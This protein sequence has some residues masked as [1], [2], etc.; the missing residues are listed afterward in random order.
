MAHNIYFTTTR[1]RNMG[2][3]ILIPYASPSGGALRWVPVYC[4]DIRTYGIDNVLKAVRKMGANGLLL[5]DDDQ[6][7]TSVIPDLYH[8]FETAA[9]EITA[10]P[11]PHVVYEAA[12]VPSTSV[13]NVAAASVPSVSSVAVTASVLSVVVDYSRDCSG[14]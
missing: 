6:T 5:S 7:D 4:D 12:P 9:A 11:V 13:V 2:L 1:Q 8:A 10:G 14:C 3:P